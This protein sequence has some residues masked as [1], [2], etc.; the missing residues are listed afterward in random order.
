MSFARCALAVFLAAAA[1]LPFTGWIPG[2]TPSLV[3]TV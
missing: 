2:W 1:L 3:I